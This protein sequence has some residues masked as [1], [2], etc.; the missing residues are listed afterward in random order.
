MVQA[1]AARALEAVEVPSDEDLVQVQ[2]VEGERS[3]SVMRGPGRVMRREWDGRSQHR[4]WGLRVRE[5]R[6]RRRRVDW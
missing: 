3:P 5:R 4:D 1:E 6:E 2:I